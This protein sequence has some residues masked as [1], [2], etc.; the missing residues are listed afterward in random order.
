MISTSGHLISRFPEVR[1]HRARI[2]S[3]L[4]ISATSVSSESL[5]RNAIAAFKNAKSYVSL[6]R[7]R[8]GAYQNR[9]EHTINNL[10][11]VVENTTAAESQIRDTDMARFMVE[12]ARDNILQNAAQAMLAQANQN[13][14][15]ILS[16]LQ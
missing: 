5:A 1:F 2:F 12:Y 7:S 15:G 16:L 13:S 9:L 10:N 14:Q 3:L 11:N 6:E 4:N 8:M